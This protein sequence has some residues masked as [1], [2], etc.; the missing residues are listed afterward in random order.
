MQHLISMRSHCPKDIVPCLFLLI[1]HLVSTGTFTLLHMLGML[2]Q[3]MCHCFVLLRSQDSLSLMHHASAAGSRTPTPSKSDS[4][5]QRSSG[6]S[7]AKSRQALAEM[8]LNQPST[9]LQ[10]SPESAIIA[11][12]RRQPA[13]QSGQ[14]RDIREQ[15][16]Y[17]KPVLQYSQPGMHRCDAGSKQSR[18][19]RWADTARQL[20]QQLLQ[21]S[22][23]P[24]TRS[25]TDAS[26]ENDLP[27]T[28]DSGSDQMSGHG[29][30][31]TAIMKQDQTFHAEEL[32]ALPYVHNLTRTAQPQ[33]Q[34]LAYPVTAQNFTSGLDWKMPQSSDSR[35]DADTAANRSPS[36]NHMPGCRQ[37]TSERL[38]LMQPPDTAPGLAVAIYHAS[39]F[40]QHAVRQPSVAQ[41]DCS[42]AMAGSMHCQPGL[43]AG[44][45]SDL[46]A[47]IPLTPVLLQ[48]PQPRDSLEASI[49]KLSGG[50]RQQ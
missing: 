38:D 43:H 27:N 5:R 12:Q 28:A 48:Q 18:Q 46:S 14:Q 10:T 35:H 29:G 15:Q 34:S 31:S 7:P 47:G 32:Q 22:Q 26:S 9:S 21:G 42:L 2:H 33:L 36:A 23:P 41:H 50:R 20:N 11:Q 44:K 49:W 6:Q 17:P 37:Y 1:L 4:V 40:Q 39:E 30:G 25:R 19:L 16:L 45:K 13:E 8:D 24:A 3:C